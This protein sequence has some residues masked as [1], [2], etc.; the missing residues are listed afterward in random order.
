MIEKKYKRCPRCDKKNPLYQD[1]CEECGLVFSRLKNVTNSAAKKAISKK[2]YN[3]VINYNVLPPDLNK[4]KLFF[5]ALFLGW[6]GAHYVKV[7]KYKTF[8]YMVISF[9]LVML[10]GTTIIPPSWFDHQY[11]FLVAWGC[12]APAGFGTIFWVVSCVQILFGRFKVPVAIDESLVKQNLDTNA[13]TDIMTTINED[14]KNKKEGKDTQDNKNGE[15][16]GKVNNQSKSKKA[17]KREKIRVICA[18]CG[19]Y[20]KVYKDETICPK[21]DEPLKEE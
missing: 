9:V 7:G 15:T 11:L 5:L 19:A 21:C 6:I 2:E 14:R 1:R 10:V 17:L 8:I 4:W 20:V 16:K 18:S 12:V 13:V 3:K